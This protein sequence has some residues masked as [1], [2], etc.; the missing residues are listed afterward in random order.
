[1]KTIFTKVRI[2]QNLATK[3]ATEQLVRK[4][5]VAMLHPLQI[6][7]THAGK[8]QFVISLAT[9]HQTMVIAFNMTNVHRAGIIMVSKAQ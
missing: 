2:V 3:I 6:V 9:L 4:L 5:A 8:V 7:R 1:M